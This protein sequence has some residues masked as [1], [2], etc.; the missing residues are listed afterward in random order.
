MDRRFWV[1]R[2]SLALVA[3]AAT[4][5]CKKNATSTGVAAPAGMTP[6]DV[7]DADRLWALAPKGTFAGAVLTK[8]GATMAW[9]A[10][11][12]LLAHT[13][14]WPS[15]GAQLSTGYRAIMQE[16]TGSPTGTLA[17]AGLAPGPAAMFMGHDQMVFVLP[18]IDRSKFVAAAHGKAATDLQ[19]GVDIIDALQCAPRKGY[20]ACAS[21][22]ALLD[23]LGS[24]S[25]VGRVANVGARGDLE[26]VADF[27]QAPP[28]PFL[29]KGTGA[30]VV[31]MGAGQAIVRATMPRGRDGTV[32]DRKIKLDTTGAAGF[33]L[34]DIM[35]LLKLSPESEGN[36]EQVAA[37]G[38]DGRVTAVLPAGSMN[39][40]AR[41]W[42]TDETFANQAIGKCDQAPRN[43]LVTFTAANGVCMVTSTMLGASAQ[44]WVQDKQVRLAITQG[45][46]APGLDVPRSALGAE[47]ADGS[48]HVALWGRGV[49]V[50]TAA[51]AFK[52]LPM[53]PMSPTQ[54]ALA[55]RIVSLISEFGVG[56]D[57]RSDDIRV[58][59]GLRT[60]LS[61]SPALVAEF[62]QALGGL[63]RG[64][65]DNATLATLAQKYP[66][67]DFAHDYRSGPIGLL[68]P[69]SVL[70]SLASVAIPAYLDYM[71]KSKTTESELHL[72]RLRKVNTM[73]FNE[74]GAFVV[75]TTPLV[76]ALS[77]CEINFQNK[78]K[79]VGGEPEWQ[80]PTW[81]ALG[82]AVLD[83]HY[84]QYQYTGTA[85]S[86]KA[87][88]VADLDCD[89]T[90]VTYTMEGRV[91]NGA[92]LVTLNRPLNMD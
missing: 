28:N 58:V 65:F 24:E 72:N 52:Q 47:L 92:P 10:V 44:A 16:L 19:T 15:G 86:F 53:L 4:A 59:A 74:D 71:S 70:G 41:V 43:P 77:C 85:T 23:Q 66:G 89:G 36:A 56:V 40:D 61:N 20:Y 68:A 33:L 2:A 11:Q 55:V 62:N 87:I 79:C 9:T 8:Q 54:I 12:T 1:G 90:T 3:I 6:A 57:V 22:V 18:V 81:Q 35:P 75:G 5:A 76:P 60:V 13:Q 48:W 30:A 27:S 45:V 78:K 38:V 25:W 50:D 49:A 82:V 37:V 88:A 34:M 32:F 91:E 29:A 67:S 39:L 73:K 51:S 26:F 80:D 46:V 42:L 21:S 14:A 17:D 84:Y 64:Q 63:D 69:V 83:P 7:A 31:Q